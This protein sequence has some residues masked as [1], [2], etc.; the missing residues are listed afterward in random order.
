MKHIVVNDE[1][2][3]RLKVRSKR[4][5]R[6]IYGLAEHLIEM[7]EQTEKNLPTGKVARYRKAEGRP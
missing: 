5:K 2:H 7:G 3:H 4:E 6:A 1:L